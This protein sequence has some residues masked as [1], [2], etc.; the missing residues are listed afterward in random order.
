MHA[1]NARMDRQ[2]LELQIQANQDRQQAE[3]DRQQAEKERER[4][5]LEAENKRERDRLEAEKERRAFNK[6]IAEMTDA[7][8]LMI[9]NMVWPNLKRI[10]GEVFQ[11]GPV[12]FEGIRLKRRS[13]VSP[14]EMME[15]DLMAVGESSVLICEAKSKADVEKVRAFLE[16]LRRFAE[17]YPEHRALRLRPMVASIAFGPSVLAF[18]TSQGVLALGFG[19]ETMELLNPEVAGG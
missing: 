2:I 5:R 6:R 19:A 7:Q 17:F 4:D 10:A 11:G 14:G 15:L 8:G 12:L 1:W 13:P 16:S 9:E 18:M 3:K